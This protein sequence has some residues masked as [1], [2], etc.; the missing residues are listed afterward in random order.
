MTA[1]WSL[2]RTVQCAKCPWKVDTD[3]YDIPRGYDVEKHRGLASTIAEPG[4]FNHNRAM[5]CHE[6]HEEYCVGWLVHQLG[7]GNNIGLRL[8]MFSCENARD[9][10]VIGE[11][12]ETFEDTLP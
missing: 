3:P 11:Q 2:K 6:E 5:S 1:R 10:R 7:P 4:S 12:H 8:Q 9:I